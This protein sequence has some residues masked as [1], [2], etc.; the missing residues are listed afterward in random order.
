MKI[1]K[2]SNLRE[3]PLEDHLPEFDKNGFLIGPIRISDESVEALVSKK[4]IA[5][6]VRTAIAQLPDIYRAILMLRDIE[7]FSSTEVANLLNIEDGAVRT[8]LH[9]ARHALKKTLEP[10][11]GVTYLND[12][13]R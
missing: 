7:G 5:E 13:L 11:L 12:I 4:E 10:T 3:Q 9:R 6:K 2:K 8:R 1:R